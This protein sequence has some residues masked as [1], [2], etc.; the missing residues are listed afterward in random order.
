VRGD[1]A[2]K[3]IK[4][5]IDA[6]TTVVEADG[7]DSSPARALAATMRLVQALERHGDLTAED[8][9]LHYQ[10]ASSA[11]A[12][13]IRIAKKAQM[14]ERL[15]SLRDHRTQLAKKVQYSQQ[16]ERRIDA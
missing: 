8:K 9:S 13:A 1:D 14:T 5:A 6:F 12:D 11:L 4:A 7:V 10:A 15:D 3:H 2:I 16:Q